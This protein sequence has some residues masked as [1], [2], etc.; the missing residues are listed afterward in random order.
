MAE[1]KDVFCFSA[2]GADENLRPFGGFVENTRENR[3]KFLKNARK[4]YKPFLQNVFAD[5][6]PGITSPPLPGE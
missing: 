1:K 2:R 5:I 6:F 3:M 4:Y